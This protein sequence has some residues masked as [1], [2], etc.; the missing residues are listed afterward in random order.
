MTTCEHRRRMSDGRCCDCGQSNVIDAAV[1]ASEKLLTDIEARIKPI[2]AMREAAITAAVADCNGE[3]SDAVSLARL[4]A[5]E[6][7]DVAN[8]KL[9]SE[10]NRLRLEHAAAY[11]AADFDQFE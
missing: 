3:D 6:E 2:A 9:T 7:W 1:A 8:P 11:E 5:G 4:T 10:L